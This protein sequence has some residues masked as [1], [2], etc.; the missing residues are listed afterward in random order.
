MTNRQEKLLGRL[1]SRHGRRKAGFFLAEGLRCCRE[2]LDRYGSGIEF[3]VVSR[4]FA[5]SADA[6][7]F[8]VLG[9]RLE[10]VEDGL[11]AQ[12]ASTENPQGILCVCLRPEPPVPSAADPFALILDRIQEPG[13]MGTI[14]RTAAAIGLT[15]VWL[16]DGTTDPYAPK[17]I[18]AG[19]GAQFS[20]Q[21]HSLPALGAARP[22]LAEIGYAP[23]WLAVPHEGTDCYSDDFQ[24]VGSGLVIGNEANG[25]EDMAAGQPVRIPM[26]GAAESLNAAQAATILLFE[27]VRRQ[28]LG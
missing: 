21:L 10:V 17:A 20:L 11:F 13:N 26:P 18:R 14:L 12:I 27:A 2:A 16:T 25:I 28:I 1:R 5:D 15:C 22:L 19:M 24:L 4:S 3:A 8:A 23:L 6:A 9:D 7:A